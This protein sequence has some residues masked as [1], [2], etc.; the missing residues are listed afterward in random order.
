M[1]HEAAPAEIK[2][3]RCLRNRQL[4]DYKFRRQHVIGCYIA[5]F[6]CHEV[7]LIVEIDGATHEHRQVYDK[8]RTQI[9]NRGGAKV[10]RFMNEDVYDFTD[11][12][13]EAILEQCEDMKSTKQLERSNA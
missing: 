12:V 9:L 13:L 4:N 3:W 8:R 1:R 10:I 11:S 5:D 2:L 6:Y 7:E